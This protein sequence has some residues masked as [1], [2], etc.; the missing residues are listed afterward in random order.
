MASNFEHYALQGG[1]GAVA[2]LF[3]LQYAIP[4]LGQQNSHLIYS[5]LLIL[6]ITFTT[7]NSYLPARRLRNNKEYGCIWG[8]DVVVDHVNL[9]DILCS[10]QKIQESTDES[11]L[12]DYSTD[13]D[14]VNEIQ[15]VNRP[16]PKSTEPKIMK[17]VSP[18]VA[19]PLRQLAG[20][21]Y[22]PRVPT[23]RKYT[24]NMAQPAKKRK[25]EKKRTKDR[26]K[27]DA[28]RA[29]VQNEEERSTKSCAQ[30]HIAR[31]LSSSHTI[32][33][34]YDIPK[35]VW[36]G[37]RLGENSRAYTKDEALAAE[38]GMR[39][40]PW[41][42]RETK[43]VRTSEHRLALLGGRPNNGKWM[44][45]M[46][47]VLRL[48]EW[49]HDNIHFLKAQK[50]TRRG[51]YDNIRTGVSY[52]GG[53][54]EPGNLVNSKHNEEIL[55]VLRDSEA[56]QQ[57]AGYADYLMKTYFR[58]LHTLY[59]NVQEKLQVDNPEL[60]QNFARCCFAACTFNFGQ[61]VTRRHTDYLNLLFGL[62]AVL[63]V[64]SYNPEEGGHLIL[65]GLRLVIEFPFNDLLQESSDF[66]AEGPRTDEKT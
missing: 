48:L 5:P 61:A 50:P 33:S 26:S 63:P 30:R 20:M 17:T 57:V 44:E 9:S 36:T 25:L 1:E 10:A 45:Y 12:T 27:R 7:D 28:E 60:V 23:E 49:A 53:Q 14:E 43:L 29:R 52:G 4:N 39:Y 24:A 64:G 19:T 35:G 13:N 3:R 58:D 40:I 47:E 62:C 54:T 11:D 37:P 66:T 55:Q 2:L 8:E 6:L 56:I 32:Q 42:G 65:W 16:T 34:E 15:T 41:D 38:P 22:S 31:T 18:P 51:D 59:T 21:T 46:A